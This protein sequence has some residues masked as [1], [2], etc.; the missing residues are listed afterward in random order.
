MAEAYF[1]RTNDSASKADYTNKTPFPKFQQQANSP[2]ANAPADANLMLLANI[3]VTKPRL[4][5]Y[6]EGDYIP[7]EILAGYLNIY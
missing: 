2:P 3:A 7:P 6:F 5:A 4:E 1:Y